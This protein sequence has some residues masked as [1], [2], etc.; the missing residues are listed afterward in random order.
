MFGKNRLVR[1]QE[2][3][4]APAN[5]LVVTSIFHTIQGEG[6]LAG[7]VATFIRLTG[8]NLQCSF[9]DTYFD[10]GTQL[11]FEEIILRADQARQKF[12]ESLEMPEHTPDPY[13]VTGTLRK[14]LVITGGEPTL[15]ANLTDFITWLH[16]MFPAMYRVQIESNG[17]FP[18]KP[19]NSDIPQ[20]MLVIS[21]KINERTGEYVKVSETAL[22]MAKALKF[23]IDPYAQG[24]GDVP[25][26]ALSWRD[27]KPEV[28]EIY[29]T[30][31]N[32][33]NHAPVKTGTDLESRSEGDERI[34]FW[35]PGLLDNDRNQEAHELAA[36]LAMKYDAKLS[37]QLHL[38]AS[39]P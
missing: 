23:V 17:N 35:T 1:P 24:Y 13:L 18:L 30:P 8:C 3:H 7:T 31:M 15:Q 28:R 20:P 38:Y 34:S 10:Q 16:R 5:T 12:W 22:Q 11:T 37:L 4:Q 19:M 25:H 32:S 29:L 26:W 21:P 36:L 2:Y 9:C 6:P 27:N 39:L 33:Y 14:L